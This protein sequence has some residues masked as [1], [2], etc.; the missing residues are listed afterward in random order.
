MVAQ[1]TGDIRLLLIHRAAI[2]YHI[3]HQTFIAARLL[4]PR[5][6]HCAVNKIMAR[7]LRFYLTQLNA[8]TA[9]LNL[10][11]YTTD[12]LQITV[13]QPARQITRLVQAL[14]A[15]GITLI[16][17]RIGNEPLSSQLSIVKIPTGQTQTCNIEFTH[18]R[19]RHWL[20]M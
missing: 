18:D 11:I 13:R 7:Q 4:L 6:H 12:K 17:E 20:I 14:A 10:I 3:R 15:V 19:Y 5:Q 1:Y 9:D 16:V 2:E 8:K